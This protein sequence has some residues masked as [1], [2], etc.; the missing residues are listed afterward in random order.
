[1]V[2]DIIG[3]TLVVIFFIR[4]YM[5]G[6]IV[7]AFSLLAIVLGIICSLKLSHEFAAWLAAKHIVTSGWAQI[8]SFVVL[9][10]GI[11]FG[12]R[13]VAKA[14]ETSA[15]AMMLG[16]VNS[17]IGG[18]LYALMAAV[19]WSALLWLA[20]QM[21]LI[22]PET[23]ADSKTYSYTAPIAP[24]TFDKIGSVWPMVKSLFADLQQYFSGVNKP[25][26]VDTAR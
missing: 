2:I 12:V 19:I 25:A 5:K 3:I 18:V 16:W 13:L 22:S 10:V 8:V 7:A 4:G 17:G 20:A 21:S 14:L 24:W 11:L 1:M 6:I 9:F 23:I 15:R 26:H